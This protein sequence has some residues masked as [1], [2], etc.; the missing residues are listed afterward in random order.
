MS[1]PYD[2]VK[3]SGNR[4]TFPG[5]AV[6]DCDETKPMFGLL[7]VYALSRVAQHY[8]NGR[9]KYPP[10]QKD[11]EDFKI[12]N[13]RRGIDTQQAMESLLR[14]AFAYL[15]GARDEDHMAAV[16]FN[17]FLIMETEEMVKRGFLPKTLLTLPD[18]TKP[19]TAPK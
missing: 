13:W 16:I 2:K 9:K 10:E 17:A 7:P 11:G 1:Q 4:R 12:E 19:K 18:W 14:H 8:K 6:R 15:E 3:D 5:G